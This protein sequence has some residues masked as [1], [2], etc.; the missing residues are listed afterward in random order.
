MDDEACLHDIERALAALVRRASLP[1]FHDHI[2][3]MARVDI[4]RTLYP[5]L[6]RIGDEEPIRLSDLAANLG[7]D[8]STVSRGVAQL[9]AAGLVERQPDPAD[10]RASSLR[11]TRAGRDGLRRVRAAWRSVV[12]ELVADWSAKDRAE[13]ARLLCRLSDAIGEYGTTPATKARAAL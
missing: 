7:L 8:L 12:T 11:L 3:A 5:V 6:G 10:G 9:A 2:R 13:L 4:D 1:R